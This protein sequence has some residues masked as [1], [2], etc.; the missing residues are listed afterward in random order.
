MLSRYL[1]DFF[2]GQRLQNE[3]RD[4]FTRWLRFG[5]TKF[6]SMIEIDDEGHWTMP[7]RAMGRVMQFLD[8]QQP[9]WWT[10]GLRREGF[11]LYR[12]QMHYYFR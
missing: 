3:L 4:H 2:A 7:I 11:D 1:G 10:E 8:D 5:Q 6:G 9:A 12:Q